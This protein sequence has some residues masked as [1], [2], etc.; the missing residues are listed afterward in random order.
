MSPRWQAECHDYSKETAFFSTLVMSL[1]TLLTMIILEEN[2]TVIWNTAFGGYNIVTVPNK[3]QLRFL[4]EGER[5][6]A[7][8]WS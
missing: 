1:V 3:Y 8:T 7:Q 2:L 4:I 5:C 6:W